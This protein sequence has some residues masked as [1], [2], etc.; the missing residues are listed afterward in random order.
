MNTTEMD[1]KTSQVHRVLQGLTLSEAVELFANLFIRL[2]VTAM[3]G[4]EE[5]VVESP[6]DVL[7]LVQAD[8]KASGETLANSLARQGLLMLVWLDQGESNV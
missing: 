1:R 3:P 8:L 4:G 2:G 5:A 6:E 7:Q